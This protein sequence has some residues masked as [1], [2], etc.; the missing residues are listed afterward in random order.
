MVRVETR[1]QSIYYI[2]LYSEGSGTRKVEFY[3][4]YPGIKTKNGFAVFWMMIFVPEKKK[5]KLV[6]FGTFDDYV[7]LALV[8]LPIAISLPKLKTQ[9]LNTNSYCKR[10][11]SI[12]SVKYVVRI[13]LQIFCLS[14][15]FPPYVDQIS[16]KKNWRSDWWAN[17]LYL[18]SSTSCIHKK[19]KIC[20]N[21]FHVLAKTIIRSGYIF[22]FFWLIT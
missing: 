10:W 19:K 20:F 9:V 7:N 15:I 3:G 1:I 22:C 5:E 12:I 13:S 18:W 8:N 11:W 16:T 14:C 17:C 6:Y 21:G 2:M 4:T